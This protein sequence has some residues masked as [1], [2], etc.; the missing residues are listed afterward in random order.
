[1][2]GVLGSFG[3]A[4]YVADCVADSEQAHREMAASFQALD[5]VLKSRYIEEKND[6]MEAL[7]Y[8]KEVLERI[9][10]KINN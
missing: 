9:E 7:K 2:I 8:K 6:Y 4:N 10:E 5:S 1:M 3:I